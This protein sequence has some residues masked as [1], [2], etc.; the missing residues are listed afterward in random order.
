MSFVSLWNLLPPSLLQYH[1]H[2]LFKVNIKFNIQT[3]WIITHHIFL[4]TITFHFLNYLDKW[5][6]TQGQ[7]LLL[8]L[9]LQRKQE[10]P[11]SLNFRSNQCII[12]SST[13]LLQIIFVFILQLPSFRRVEVFVWSRR[14][15]QGSRNHFTI[16]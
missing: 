13:L 10:T 15:I 4:L 1:F 7:S 9:F 14:L 6:V 5:L 3:H 8:Y 16:N 12:T 2:I 11:P